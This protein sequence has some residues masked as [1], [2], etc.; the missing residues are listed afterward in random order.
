MLSNLIKSKGTGKLKIVRTLGPI[1]DLND[2]LIELVCLTGNRSPEEA[3]EI[4][5]YYGE[6]KKKDIIVVSTQV[7]CPSRCNFC[8]LGRMKFV[9]NL[10]S[11]EIVDQSVLMLAEAQRHG[12]DLD[13]KMKKVNFAKSGDPLFNAEFVDA[14]DALAEYRF[15][16][17][18]STVFPSGTIPYKTFR[19][20]SSFASQYNEPVQ[21][22]ISLISTSEEYRNRAAGIKIAT[23]DEIG[24]FGSHW[25][26]QNPTGRKINLS[27]ILAEETPVNSKEIIEKLHPDLFRIRLR[28]YVP[29][30]NGVANGLSPVSEEKYR[31][32]MANLIE[33]GYEVSDSGRPTH[34]ER[35]VGVAS[36]ITL[37]RY[38]SEKAQVSRN[39][40]P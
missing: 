26:N 28:D 15:S 27:L 36:N 24:H 21:I 9:R 38:L 8:E 17:K 12:L 5:Y 11:Q 35:I 1:G 31:S 20:V 13:R 37:S 32:A 18:V 34:A 3:I 14:L 7:G 33:A 23:F 39:S 10:R 30:D 22:Q 25:R 4:G 40:K 2:G 19:D 6:D 29:T 16:F